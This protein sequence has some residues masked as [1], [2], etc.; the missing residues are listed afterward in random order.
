[1]SQVNPV[2]KS[3]CLE[4]I[5]ESNYLKLLDLI[6]DLHKINTAAIGQFPNKP[7]LHLKIIERNA[8]TLTVQLTHCFLDAPDKHIE[9]AVKIRLYG[10]A[11]LAEVLRDHSRVDV[12]RAIT[13][14]GQSKQI[15]DYK[16]SLNYFL[17]KWLDYCLQTDY[18]FDTEVEEIA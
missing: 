7:S 10:D 2:N 13:D 9:P 12:F 18:Q 6:P 4:Q 17:G 8:Y 1:M 14:T 16:W 11:K 15:M 5:C 3:F